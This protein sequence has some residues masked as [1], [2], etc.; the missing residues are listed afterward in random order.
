MENELVRFSRAGD[1]FHYCW[2]ARRCLKLLYPKSTLEHIVVEG[3]GAED[4]DFDGEYVVDVAEYYNS[5]N[6]EDSRAVIYYQL[7][8]TTVNIH[9][10]F[11]LSDLKNTIEG[12]AAR[13]SEHFC[14]ATRSSISPK[15]TFSIITNRPININIKENF[16]QIGAG[17]SILRAD[18]DMVA[19]ERNVDKRVRT[20]L[21]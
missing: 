6:D 18:G 1:E 17:K 12:F 5:T 14:Q 21:S 2:A 15:V 4:S 7:K 19:G 3:S 8:H 13:Y 16:A 11:I 9:N 10:A 20:V